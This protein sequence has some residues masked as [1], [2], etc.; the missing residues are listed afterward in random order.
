VKINV[1]SVIRDHLQTLRK[2]DSGRISYTDI[3]VFYGLPIAMSSVSIMKKLTIE[4]DGYSVSITF[5]GIFI[6]LLLNIQVAIFAIFQ[7]KWET[8]LDNRLAKKQEEQLKYRRTLLSELNSNIYYLTLISC[9]GVSAVLIFYLFKMKSGFGP[10]V[11]V[12]IYAH[13]ILTFVMII[14]RSHA[15]FQKEYRD[16]P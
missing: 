9:I 13:F 16:S 7:R 8:P 1:Y 3:V 12:F 5:F 10:A 14:K 15:L 4:A 6:A 11:L 2:A